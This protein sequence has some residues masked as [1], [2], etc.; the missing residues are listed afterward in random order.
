LGVYSDGGFVE[1]SSSSLQRYDDKG[2]FLWNYNVD[3]PSNNRRVAVDEQD[4]TYAAILDG[5]EEE[6]LLVK[7]SE[8]G[9]VV[10]TVPGIH[11]AA[12]AFGPGEEIVTI[13]YNGVVQK[14]SPDGELVWEEELGEQIAVTPRGIVVA[15]DGRVTVVGSTQQSAAERNDSDGWIAQLTADGALVF[16]K[17]FGSDTF[18]QFI[19]VVVNAEGEPVAVGTSNADL[20]GDGEDW[21]ELLLVHFSNEGEPVSIIGF[22]KDNAEPPYD[23]LE[24][25]YDMG[26]DAQGNIVVVSG[27]TPEGVTWDAIV[28]VVSP[29]GVIDSGVPLLAGG[30][31]DS[32]IL[33]VGQGGHQV[34][35]GF[36]STE[37]NFLARFSPG[38]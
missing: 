22:E 29:S 6:V 24:H 26:V 1:A 21:E 35:T 34:I 18:D 32:F 17:T 33:G 28:L 14:R 38:L 16:E 31:I 9:E 37:D 11:F 20:D 4:N 23:D 30:Y 7:L 36:G 13:G 25:P 10:W 8:A 15:P 12:L 27:Y 2:F 3:G 19:G 5:P